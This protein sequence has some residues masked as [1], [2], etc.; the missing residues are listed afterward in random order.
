MA[1]K[2]NAMASAPVAAKPAKPGKK[3]AKSAKPKAAGKGKKGC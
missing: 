1:G 3:A 2:K